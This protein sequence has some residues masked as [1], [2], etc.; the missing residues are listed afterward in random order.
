M[1]YVSILILVFVFVACNNSKES[2]IPTAKV[3]KETF[4]ID[5]YEEG[6][7]KAIQSINISSPTI[8][9]RYGML[10]ITQLVDD[11]KEV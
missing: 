2:E 1:K 10:K 8:S 6:E 9:W 5:I 4:Y 11:G 3:K 7:V